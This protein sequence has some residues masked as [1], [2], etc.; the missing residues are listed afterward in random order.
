MVLCSVGTIGW[1]WWLL[2][3]LDARSEDRKS[4][5]VEKGSSVSEIAELLAQKGVI[6]SPSA[7]SLR[8]RFAGKQST[9]QA[10]TFILRPSMSVDEIMNI[11]ETGTAEELIITIPEGFTVKQ[12]DALLTE[13]GVSEP[14]VVLDC[15]QHCDFSSFGFLPDAANLADRGGKLEGYLFP[16]TYYITKE[17]FVPKFFLERLL[18]TFRRE[19]LDMYKKDI[20][21]SR[22]SLHEIVTMASLIEEETLN[23][24]QRSTVSGILWKRFDDGRGLGVDATV[25]YVLDRPTEEITVADLNVNS[26][27]NT[28][29]FKGLPPG[30]IANPG[31][32][33]FLAALHPK[34][35]LYWYYLHDAQGIIHYAVTNEEHNLNRMKYLR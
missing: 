10:G 23:D 35:S 11:L 26:P 1:Y 32:R 13:K 19:V 22:R 25:R 5:M 9:L 15:A 21:G 18:T 16:D 31:L 27:Y 33:S 24:A 17:D 12:I 20:D 28:R 30:P 8:A 7:F 6:R 3:P 2:R 29:K 34:D 14:G 4:V